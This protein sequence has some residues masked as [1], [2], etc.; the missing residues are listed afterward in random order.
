MNT[1][2]KY[3]REEL[4]ILKA[5]SVPLRKRRTKNL[6]FGYSISNAGLAA[7]GE[8]GGFTLAL[9]QTGLVVVQEY[10]FEMIL[11]EERRYCVPQICVDRIQDYYAE[12]DE[13]IRLLYAPD[14]G[15]CD[16]TSVGFFFGKKWIDGFNIAYRNEAQYRHMREAYPD[17]LEYWDTVMQAENNIMEIFFAICRILK[18]YNVILD[19]RRAIVMGDAIVAI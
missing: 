6:L 14:N 15:S 3:S 2:I 17:D 11:V 19:D 8:Y 5:A 13:T 7:Y 16:G 1:N 18:D 9:Y 12:Q 4:D 10:L